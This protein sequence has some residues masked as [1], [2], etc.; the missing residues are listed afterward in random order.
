MSGI[1]ELLANPATA[2]DAIARAAATAGAAELELCVRD[3]A[4]LLRHPAIVAAMFANRAAPM[5]LNSLPMKSFPALFEI[6][7]A[8]FP[9]SMRQRAPLL[10]RI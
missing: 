2:D 10:F 4:R 9:R 7:P 8:P 1:A 3:E 5:A 6:S